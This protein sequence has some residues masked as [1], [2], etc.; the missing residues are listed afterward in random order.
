MHIVLDHE[1]KN[2]VQQY[3]ALL[4][5]RYERKHEE[6]VKARERERQQRRERHDQEQKM[7]KEARNALP[8]PSR[9]GQ[10]RDDVSPTIARHL[11]ALGHPYICL[12]YTSDAADDVI[13]VYISVVAV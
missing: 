12:L 6:R 5:E 9:W 10:K 3:R 1:R 7:A 4:K 13:D 8:R 2:Y 11:V